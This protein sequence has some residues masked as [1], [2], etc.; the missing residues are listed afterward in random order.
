MLAVADVDLT[1]V[2]EVMPY[3]GLLLVVGSN[4]IELAIDHGSEQRG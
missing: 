1:I 3:V 4:I 2:R